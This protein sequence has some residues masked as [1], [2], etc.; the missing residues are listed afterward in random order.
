MNLKL[1]LLF[2]VVTAC[3]AACGTAPVANTDQHLT[4]VSA[5]ASTASDIPPPVRPVPL[6]PPPRATAKAERYSVVVNAV[7]VQELLFALA[8]DAKVNVDVHPGIEGTITLNA[9]NQTLPQILTRIAKQVDVRF[10]MDGPNLVVMPDT[11][12]LKNYKI[13]YVNM[14]RDT[15]E[16][17]S[18][19][20]QI[21]TTGSASVGGTGGRQSAGGGNNSTTSVTNTS[22]NHFWETLTQNVKDILRETDKVFPEGSYEAQ[23]AQTGQQRGAA[24]T[25]GRATRRP[26]GSSAA[27]TPAP[28]GE[29]A[30]EQ[31]DTSVERRFTFR[32]A[33]SVIANA[34][35]G[36]LN[37]RATSRQHEK[38]QEFIDQVMG[39]ARRQ[40]LIEATIVEV[41]LNDNYQAGV[42]WGRL[43]DLGK[44]QLTLTQQV[45]PSGFNIAGTTV[46]ALTLSYSPNGSNI[47]STIKLLSDF[48]TTRV[49]SSP[50]IMVLNN[51]SAVMKVV[52]NRVYF[53]VKADT[54]TNQTTFNTTFTTTAISVPIGFVMNLTPQ[55]SEDDVVSLNVRPTISRITGFVNDPNP[56]LKQA[57]VVNAVPE[58]QTRELESVLKVSSGQ[59]AI[60]GG[61]MQDNVATDRTG[62]PV[63]SRLPL[64]GNA[65]SYRNDTTTKNELVIFLRPTVIRDASVNGDLKSVRSLLPD[66]RFLKRPEAELIPGGATGRQP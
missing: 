61:L 40:V 58:I 53:D 10:E 23:A 50:K 7:P 33:A 34:E 37:V 51:Q 4:A 52:D 56:S 25:P 54:T 45:S 46:P 64:V 29:A 62:V 35:S 32:E 28:T 55:I 31:T 26:S 66:D 42:D 41:N 48:G 36:V 65:F 30:A 8:R 44:G 39:S 38:V 43:V 5:P 15:T 11:P 24:V 19:A 17:I 3:L 14:T 47:A 59:I 12:Y 1:S 27:I 63:L 18:L 21:S 20:T 9:I 6:P 60:L 49:L 2:L 22:T 57:G 13:D 16:T